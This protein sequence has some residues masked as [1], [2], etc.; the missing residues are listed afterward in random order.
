LDD[1]RNPD[2]LFDLFDRLANKWDRE[3]E[4]MSSPVQM[5]EHIAYQQIIAIGEDAIP[6]I[7]RRMRDYGGHWFW[8][9]AFLTNSDPIPPESRGK[10]AE[11]SA[12]W[13]RWGYEHGYC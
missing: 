13:L 4:N 12:A 6:L 7:L 8:A 2:G 5:A 3:T 1:R 10:I 9:L 11:M